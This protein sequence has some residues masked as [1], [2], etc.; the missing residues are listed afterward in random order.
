LA[1]RSK[2][3]ERIPVYTHMRK[4]FHEHLK[5]LDV[6]ITDFIDQAI[7][8][9]LESY[10]KDDEYYIKKMQEC[11]RRKEGYR[12]LLK[13]RQKEREL[14]SEEEIK[15]NTLMKELKELFIKR[16]EQVSDD[17][18]LLKA[19]ITGK[20]NKD[21]CKRLGKDPVIVLKELQT[22]YKKELKA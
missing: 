9:K 12:S 6:N 21:R 17:E 19:W 11:D 1:N 10:G 13:E 14:K 8:E 7:G 18:E 3:Y 20:H 5:S 4:T 15:D 16:V 22:W 2:G